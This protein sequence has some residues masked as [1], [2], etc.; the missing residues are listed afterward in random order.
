MPPVAMT[1]TFGWFRVQRS[2]GFS[3]FGQAFGVLRAGTGRELR[4]L[5]CFDLIL[6][7]SPGVQHLDVTELGVPIWD[8]RR[9][10]T[11]D[12]VHL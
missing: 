10:P 9:Y 7:G 6:A 11:Q 1:G 5:G 12:T 3:I 2:V 8:L 4:R